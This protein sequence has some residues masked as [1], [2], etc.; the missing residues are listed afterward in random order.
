MEPLP[1]SVV[2][3]QENSFKPAGQLA[4]SS[5]LRFLDLPG[6]SDIAV[7]IVQQLGCPAA[8]ELLFVSKEFRKIFGDVIA[9]LVKLC[10]ARREL[11]HS[12]LFCACGL[13]D[14]VRCERGCGVEQ[15]NSTL[16]RAKLGAHRSCCFYGLS[17][18]VPHHSYRAGVAVGD[19]ERRCSCSP[20]GRWILT[21]GRWI[22]TERAETTR[23]KNRL[24]P[25]DCCGIICFPSSGVVFA[26]SARCERSRAH[27][28]WDEGGGAEEKYVCPHFGCELMFPTVG[29]ALACTA[30]HSQWYHMVEL[31]S[32]PP[33]G[34][35]LKRL[36]PVNFSSR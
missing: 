35:L 22:L 27:A 5:V 13:T 33:T 20:V 23:P 21:A 14:V 36:L 17:A 4:K 26:G 16:G 6:I 31:A 7:I 11:F 15:P 19:R 12:D 9:S 18:D 34:D 1:L 29:A 2:S 32:L 8:C 3:E 10:N 24:G 30:V 28:L 25:P